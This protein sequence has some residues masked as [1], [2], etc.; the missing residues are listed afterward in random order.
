MNKKGIAMQEQP[1][2]LQQIKQF[3][4]AFSEFLGRPK[5]IFDIKDRARLLLLLALVI[6]VL[7][8]AIYYLQ[9]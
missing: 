3:I 8:G 7:E 9:K 2:V 4:Q 1:T 5:T 6:G